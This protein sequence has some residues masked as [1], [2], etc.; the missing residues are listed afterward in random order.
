MVA[1]VN[2]S[3]ACPLRVETINVHDYTIN[4]PD[5]GTIAHLFS[6][7]SLRFL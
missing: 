6:D 1:S 2:A 5:F 3:L 4:I 7:V